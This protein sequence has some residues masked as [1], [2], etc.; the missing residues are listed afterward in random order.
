MPAALLRFIL[1]CPMQLAVTGCTDAPASAF[2]PNSDRFTE[3]TPITL[4][5]SDLLL[6]Q[7]IPTAVRAFRNLI[8]V[9]FQCDFSTEKG[10]KR[11]SFRL[12]ASELEPEDEI[13][14]KIKGIVR[15]R[16]K[17]T[18]E[19]NEIHRF[20]YC[21]HYEVLNVAPLA[22]PEINPGD[23]IVLKLSGETLLL[24]Q[25]QNKI[26]PLTV[27]F[28]KN[29]RVTVDTSVLGQIT[30]S[31][32]PYWHSLGQNSLHLSCD[33][34]PSDLILIKRDTLYF[35]VASEPPSQ[36]SEITYSCDPASDLFFYTLHFT[37]T[38]SIESIQNRLFFYPSVSGEWR[39]EKSN[40]LMFTPSVLSID[41][42]PKAIH[43]LPGKINPNSEIPTDN[44]FFWSAPEA[45]ADLFPVVQL[46]TVI[47]P[48]ESR[49]FEVGKQESDCFSLPLTESEKAN[50]VRD[51]EF[52]FNRP[53]ASNRDPEL[54]R[55]I[56]ITP[57]L[58]EGELTIPEEKSFFIPP[59]RSSLILRYQFSKRKVGEDPGLYRIRLDFDPVQFEK[60]PYNIRIK[61]TQ[62][63]I[64]EEFL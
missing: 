19:I 32:D 61:P 59:D 46:L 56:Q 30:L 16:D 8:P 2:F 15:T 10:V 11:V 39:Q 53:L 4:T 48:D 12:N 58:P 1:L 36:L 29:E 7:D 21:P 47:G 6:N 42:Y 34:L 20:L 40:Q 64:K 57:I 3:Q 17:K 43:L 22:Y 45:F 63:Y 60:S 41:R 27:Q 5:C 35:S 9:P 37:H 49:Q 62:I 14:L 50:Y 55:S 51:F 23:P 44:P 26:L 18:R 31:P 54:L 38:V 33:S 25:I 13:Y 28:K 24:E 52:T